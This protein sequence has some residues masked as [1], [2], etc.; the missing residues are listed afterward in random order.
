KSYQCG[1]HLRGG[2][3]AEGLT[4]AAAGEAAWFSGAKRAAEP[5]CERSERRIRLAERSA[6]S[7]TPELTGCEAAQ[8]WSSP[9]QRFV[10]PH[11]A[12]FSR[13][14]LSIISSALNGVVILPG[15]VQ[16]SM[17][18]CAVPNAVP[19]PEPLKNC[20][21]RALSYSFIPARSALTSSTLL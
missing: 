13:Q 21:L 4:A 7:R 8:E 9:V 10:G 16:V 19:G 15:F 14:A 6:A 5:G 17:A 2:R 3:R 11:L 12:Y 20:A 1:A 18:N